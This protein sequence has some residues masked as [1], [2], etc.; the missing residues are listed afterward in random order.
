MHC[1]VIAWDVV[2]STHFNH[3]RTHKPPTSHLTLAVT[4]QTIPRLLIPQQ[5]TSFPRKSGH[6]PHS[7]NPQPAHTENNVVS[8]AFLQFFTAGGWFPAFLR[9][10]LQRSFLLST[11]IKE[12]VFP[13]WLGIPN[14]LI[15][16]HTQ[17]TLIQ[18]NTPTTKHPI[19]NEER[20]KGRIRTK[21]F[22]TFN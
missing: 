20:T 1:V 3:T 7:R 19:P 17:H 16:L 21:K 22:R 11:T 9:S 15:F 5:I 14:G 8:P 12:Q 13:V 18:C 6:N 4:W 10:T 2:I